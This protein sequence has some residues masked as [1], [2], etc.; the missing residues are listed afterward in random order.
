MVGRVLQHSFFKRRQRR[1]RLEWQ[2]KK[3]TQEIKSGE[4]RKNETQRGRKKE[5]GKRRKKV[6][7]KK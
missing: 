4:R 2:E 7:I 6:I 3:K 1:G 5:R